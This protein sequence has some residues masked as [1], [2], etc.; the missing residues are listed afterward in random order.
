MTI[1]VDARTAGGEGV[2][3]SRTIAHT[4]TG[5]RVLLVFL[6]FGQGAGATVVASWT[7]SVPYQVRR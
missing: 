4:C 7:N 1:A 3:T 5:A 2:G 6:G